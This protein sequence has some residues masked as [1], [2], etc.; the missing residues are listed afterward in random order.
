MV[1][2][3]ITY[4][5]TIYHNYLT[6]SILVSRLHKIITRLQLEYSNI[7]VFGTA[8]VNFPYVSQMENGMPMDTAVCTHWLITAILIEK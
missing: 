2:Q 7:R 4:S 5:L 6:R 8:L 3:V 1:N